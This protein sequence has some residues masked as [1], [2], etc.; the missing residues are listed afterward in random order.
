MKCPNCNAET[1]SANRFCEY[2]GSELPHEKPNI[3]T[4]NSTVDNSQTVINN[5]YVTQPQPQPTYIPYSA[6]VHPYSSKSKI[7]ALLLDIFLGYFGAHYF[8]VGKIG[9]GILYLFT[10][11]LFYIGWIVDI[12]RIAF[13]KFTDKNGKILK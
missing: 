7:V 11:G 9:M 3:N 10:L 5:Y 1:N 2:C 8:Y 13:G 4:T 6:P 12:F